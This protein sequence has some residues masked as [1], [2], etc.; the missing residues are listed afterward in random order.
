METGLNSIPSPFAILAQ[1][2]IDR[3]V[4]K[5]FFAGQY[6]RLGEFLMISQSVFETGAL[7][8]HIFRDG[9]P[10]LMKLF[11]Q[12]GREQEVLTCLAQSATERMARVEG[13]CRGFI[14]VFFLQELRN[15]GL[16][17][18]WAGSE[19]A[20][21]AQQKIS[22]SS[23]FLSM[24]TYSME[25]IGFGFAYPELSM[26]FLEESAKPHDLIEWNEWR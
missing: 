24:Q 19:L 1:T 20:R 7:A 16:P 18:D 9:L 25:G 23:A 10:I 12:P 26:K 8:A 11:V 6:V 21:V 14:D 2:L 5:S 13:K 22:V 4:R 17:K 3:I 15:V